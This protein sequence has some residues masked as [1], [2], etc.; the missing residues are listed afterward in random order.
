MKCG[1]CV[2]KVPKLTRFDRLE[3]TWED[4]QVTDGGLNIVRYLK[5]FKPCIRKT[6]G[7]F[8][9]SVFDNLLIAETDDRN[10]NNWFN[11]PSDVERINSIP[12]G[13]IREIK[14]LT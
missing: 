2:V 13:M 6:L 3:V 5:D 9:G 10:A 4:A 14:I 1:R 8:I 12:T 7:Y 11:E